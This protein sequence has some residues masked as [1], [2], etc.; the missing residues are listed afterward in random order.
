MPPGQTLTVERVV[1]GDGFYAG[2]LE[3]RLVGVNAPELNECYGA[4]AKEWLEER[5][6]GHQVALEPT[7]LDQ[8]DRTL[9][10]VTA[11]GQWINL[12]LVSTGHAIALSSSEPSL[13]EA[14]GT[15]VATGIGLW[16]DSI[17]NASEPKQLLEI[18]SVDFNPPGQDVGES[19]A[20]HNPGQSA[21]ELSGFALRDESSVNRYEFPDVLLEAG[22]TIEVS[23]ACGSDGTVLYWCAGEPV[24]NNG[25]DS[26]L[27]ID[28]FGRI[29]ASHRYP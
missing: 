5:I 18:L 7:A 3:I 8:F 24:W 12:E 10:N 26:V 29:V 25:G 2:G 6:G 11:D 17:C 13:L 23:T 9:A 14:E 27:V 28:S 15:A 1:D 16:G 22:G 20:I 19:V 4:E 21:V